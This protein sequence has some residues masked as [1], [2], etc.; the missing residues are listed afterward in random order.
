MNRR[1]FIKKS[2][3]A[4]TLVAG[5]AAV[6]KVSSPLEVKAAGIGTK[7]YKSI[8]DIY[9][10]KKD[11][12]RFDQRNTA[13]NLSFWSAPNPFTGGYIKKAK[14]N[15]EDPSK[16]FFINWPTNEDNPDTKTL[17][18]FR[19]GFAKVL[20][21]GAFMTPEQKKRPGYRQLDWAL[22]KGAKATEA[23]TGTIFS[24]C[25][26]GSSGPEIDVPLPNGKTLSMPTSLFKQNFSS[27][28][29]VASEKWNFTSK[30]E[31]TYAVKKVAKKYGAS[32]VGIAPYDER[33][34]YNSEVHSPFD[35][36]TGL[37]KLDKFNLNTPV[38]FGFKPKSVIVIAHEMDY[39]TIKCTPAPIAGSAAGVQ[40]AAM[41]EVTLKIATFLRML[42]YNTR[43]AGNDTGLSVPLAISAGLGEGS[44]MGLLITEEFGPRVRLSK[45]YT[46]LELVPDKPK[47]FGVREFCEV[48][49]KCADVCPSEA[50][51]K[52]KTPESTDNQVSNRSTSSS[53]IKWYNDGQKC[54]TFWI[55]NNK[56]C[57][58]CV[59][60]CPYNKIEEWHH[61]ISKLATRIP[62]INRIARY[63]D[64]F[65]GYGHINT[66]E[67]VLKFW[68][69]DI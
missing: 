18:T 55:E 62:G 21:G 33:W 10:V 64:E 52:A 29:D 22:D 12:K 59:V 19:G 20:S 40:Y 36:L 47:T 27:G 28:F 32:L 14:E 24:R 45:V 16:Y 2:A 51:S 68:K 48:C 6:S 26:S 60:A 53:V 15:G 44:R 58:N 35:P 11:F 43:H 46:D 67:N 38:K 37:L 39:E 13:F 49:Q 25:F 50:I 31:A 9:E 66:E 1:E 23:L 5:T 69:K 8:D 4:T 30:E 3:V 7:K 56:G 61:D 54:L 57:M 65:F 42:G 63:L 17:E 41:A 34:I